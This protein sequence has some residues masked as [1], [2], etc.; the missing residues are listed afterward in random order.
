MFIIIN[1]SIV[2]LIILVM[3]YIDIG[4]F[5][6]NMAASVVGAM[7]VHYLIELERGNNIF[8]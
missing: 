4:M 8:V 7:I 2:L 1:I 6:I 3:M 5:Q